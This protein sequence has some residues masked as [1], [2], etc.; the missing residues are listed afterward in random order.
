[1]QLCQLEMSTL[2]RKIF[3]LAEET[4]SIRN[5]DSLNVNLVILKKLVDKLQFKDLKIDSHHVS[6]KAFQ[7]RVSIKK[8]KN[9]QSCS[10]I[11]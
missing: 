2:L 1:M 8:I 3:I 6:K 5:K 4:F 9:N 11:F 7:G 10:S